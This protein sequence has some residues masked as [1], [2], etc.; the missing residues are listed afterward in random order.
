MR[1]VIDVSSAGQPRGQIL[2]VVSIR[3]RLADVEDRAIPGHWEGDL[4]TGSQNR[5]LGGT[6]VTL[7]Y[8]GEGAGE[9]YYQRGDGTEHADTATAIGI[10]PVINLVS[11]DGD[12][13]A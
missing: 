12:G 13:P 2:D 7:H 5:H 11:R 9:R 1:C 6:L 10:A 4:V 3:D 8:A